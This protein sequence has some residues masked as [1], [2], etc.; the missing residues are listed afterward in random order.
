[1]TPR[2]VE[3]V[4]PRLT[5]VRQLYR[6]KHDNCRLASWYW[7]HFTSRHPATVTRTRGPQNALAH[8][9][10]L[11]CCEDSPF[12][13][14][15]CLPLQHHSL[16]CTPLT[17]SALTLTQRHCIF[18]ISEILTHSLILS[19]PYSTH[20]T[21]LV[22][23][24]AAFQQ[25]QQQL[26]KMSAPRTPRRPWTA[27]EDNLVLLLRQQDPHIPASQFANASLSLPYS[28]SR[29]RCRLQLY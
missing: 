19:S 21:Q 27:E 23:Q 11:G 18:V 6:T 26:S 12:T 9:S 20:L 29:S 16:S 8:V 5:A 22:Y 3:P 15:W 25:L 24:Q 2:D 7:S 28:P 1:M 13:S 17:T 4:Y 14:S 10:V